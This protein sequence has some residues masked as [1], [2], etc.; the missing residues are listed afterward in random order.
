MTVHSETPLYP[1]KP[2][3]LYRFLFFFLLFLILIGVVAGLSY[4][5]GMTEGSRFFGF[6]FGFQKILSPPTDTKSTPPVEISPI[7]VAEGTEFDLVQPGENTISFARHEGKIVLL[8][9]GKIYTEGKLEEPVD[10]TTALVNYRFIGLLDAPEWVTP[11]APMADE[12]FDLKSIP[13][14]DEFVFIMRWGKNLEGGGTS[15]EDIYHLYHYRNRDAYE[16][17]QVKV[18]SFALENNK[19]FVPRLTSFSKDAAFAELKMFP[20]WN[21]GGGIPDTGLLNLDSSEYKNIGPTSFFEWTEN[22]SYNFK[23]IKE[24]ECSPEIQMG[25]CLEKPEN[26][27]MQSRSFY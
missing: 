19:P 20:C 26:L 6:R 2:F 24:I 22:G 9:R 23:D 15:P 3:N 12:V 5:F 27:P 21:C 14:T 1:K 17:H 11:G 16:A 10:M 8:Y 13:G 7:V 4:Y 18:F 25:P